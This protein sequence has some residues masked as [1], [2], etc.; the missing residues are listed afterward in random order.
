VRNK[1]SAR[2]I[3]AQVTTTRTSG[4]SLAVWCD[5]AGSAYGGE[6]VLLENNASMAYDG[7][8]KCRFHMQSH[9]EILHCRGR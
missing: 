9:A 8:I 1:P 7:A 6:F 5:S 2:N 4:H 3:V